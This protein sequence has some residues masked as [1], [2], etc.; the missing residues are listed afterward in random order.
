[1]KVESG[2]CKSG[3][4]RMVR[5]VVMGLAA[6]FA[7]GAATASGAEL[8]S[9][10]ARGGRLYDKWYKVIGVD[11]PEESHPAYPTDAKLAESPK[12][13]WR[14][15]ECHGWDY[16]GKDGRYAKGKHATGIVG[17]RKMFGA[18]PDDVV[19]L[20][21]D[22]THGYG[23]MMNDADLM[24]LANFVTKGQLDVT[25]YIDDATKDIKGGNVAKGEEY[26]NTVC[27]NCHD[28]KGTKPK[29]L[30]EPL[31][32]A[33]DDN[34]WEVMHKILN[35]Q[36]DERMPALRAFDRQVVLDILAYT[37]TLPKTK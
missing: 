17:I 28:K 27:A 5:A 24:D 25:Q 15:K 36:P 26:F 30:D 10:I 21:K 33:A 7:L 16:R 2:A 32:E 13:N 11:P 37:R 31:G 14:C 12:D 4:G 29:T 22:D 1:M 34:P 18:N 19:A 3:H 23:D 35:G 9:S 20:L 6:G 8:E